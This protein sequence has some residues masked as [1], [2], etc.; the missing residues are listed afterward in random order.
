MGSELSSFSTS[1][2][3]AEVAAWRLAAVRAAKTSSRCTWMSFG[4]VMPK[5]TWSPRTSRT[6]TITSWPI[7]MLW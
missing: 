5:R 7:T 2:S 1:S 3:E 4:A 6:V